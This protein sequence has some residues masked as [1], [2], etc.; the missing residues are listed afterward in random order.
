LANAHQVI[1]AI[2]FFYKKRKVLK[3]QPAPGGAQDGERGDAVAEVRKDAREGIEV[4][5]HLFLAELLDLDRAPADARLLQRRDD[6]VEVGAV[7]DED[8]RFARFVT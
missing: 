8:G 6:V 3:R 1:A 5:H 4:L 7:A 2:L